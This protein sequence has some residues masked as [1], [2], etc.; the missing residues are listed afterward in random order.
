MLGA[1]LNATGT[2]GPDTIVLHAGGE[3]PNAPTL[4]FQGSS[5][6][7]QPI[8]FG[9]GMRCVGGNLKRLFTTNAV[10]GAV[11]V[12]DATQMS[13][14]ARSAALGDPLVPGSVRSYQTWYR[15]PNLSFCAPPSGDAWNLSNAVRIVW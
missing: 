14:S 4:V 6:L 1:R 9:D 7:S 11:N 5:S 12:P 2:T 10:G 8:L 3:L 15:D 13:I